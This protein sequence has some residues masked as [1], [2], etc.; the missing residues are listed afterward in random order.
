MHN[1]HSQQ[2]EPSVLSTLRSLIP[3]RS[4]LLSEALWIAELQAGR[5]LQLSRAVDVPILS[6]T[7]T[8]LPRITVEPDPDLTGVAASGS[9][10]WNW[11]RRTWIISLN[12]AEPRARQRFTLIH[13]YKHIIDHGSLGI[14]SARTSARPAEE[15]VA[16]YFAGC[17]LMPKRLLKAAYCDGIQRPADLAELF[18]V[19]PRA[20]EVRLNQIGL[21]DPLVHPHP[22]TYRY[23]PRRAGHQTSYRTTPIRQQAGVLT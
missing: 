1:T 18:D 10:H 2:G 12:P 23:Q 21:T 14:R 15:I 11:Q 20:V 7:V 9:S 3:H 22:S 4:L 5:L 8:D 13:E 17:V 6:S 16:D 19:S